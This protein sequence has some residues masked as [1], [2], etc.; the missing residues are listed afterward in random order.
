[1]S[2]TPTAA[3]ADA[4]Q[5]P[6]HYAERADRGDFTWLE[7]A[8]ED[9]LGILVTAPQ[10]RICR[11]LVEHPKLLVITANGLGKS[12]ILAAITIVWL[13]VRY[14]AVS[15][16]TSGTEK[17]MR[18]TY[19]KPVENLH[20]N[21]RI[22]LPGE[23]K[24]RPERIEFDDDPEHFFEATSP[25]DAGELEGVHTA[26]TLAIIE[27]ADKKDVDRE[28]L[29]AMD[30]LVTDEQDRIIAIAN[31]PKDETD[32]VADLQQPESQWEV[33]EFSSFESHNVQVELGAVNGEK[34]DGL[35]T[36]WKI[37][38]D[39]E[40]YNNR[41]WPGVETALEWS[42]PASDEFKDD[43]D[44]RWYRRRMGIIP[45]ANATI[46]RPIYLND[47]KAAWKRDPAP[48]Q[49]PPSGI[50]IDVAR[51][52]DRTVLIGAYQ[53]DS[54]R[55]HYEAQGTDH[56][57]QEDRLRDVLTDW[58]NRQTA[59]DAVGEGSALADNLRQ[60]YPDVRRF[61]AGKTAA[62]ETEYKDCWAEGLAVLGEWLE[63]GV[64]IAHR[65]LREELLVA[66]RVVEFEEKFYASHG[67]GGAEVLVAS[68]KDE[69]K[70]R[71]ER[72]P[73]YLD[74]ALQAVL[75]AE[76][77]LPEPDDGPSGSGTW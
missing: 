46:H 19:C 49:E 50:G 69:I 75:A 58:P 26:Y 27:E 45:P 24:S 38:E 1:M 40:D 20:Q 3:D 67:D 39:W 11:A 8:I 74:A 28:V 54:L 5:P 44:E 63:D 41:E 66:A 61:K 16:A 29:D 2:T 7:D 65:K 31:P 76:D 56:V 72:S 25:K 4:P 70:E 57:V 52:G 62:T 43:L 33:L 73:D 22:P 60:A 77:L 55:V 14:P 6:A 71:L 12:Y 30:S 42:D 32:V 48:G 36:L 68:P 51:S 21:A 47:V 64:A 17:K 37:K 35:A 59:I 15:F 10:R 13:L 18:R 23:Y 34:I 9:Y 53:D